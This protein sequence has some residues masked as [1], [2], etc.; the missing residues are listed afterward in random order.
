MKD[1]IQIN[2]VWYVRE[3]ETELTDNINVT[4]V[5]Q[6]TYETDEYA[7]EASRIYKDDLET[8]YSGVDVKFTDKKK[9]Y[10]DYWDNN[11]YLLGVLNNDNYFINLARENMNV[12]GIKDFKNFIYYLKEKG[13]FNK[14]NK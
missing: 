9:N 14:E 10:D 4:H 7:W 11:D 1:R 5:Q 12:E 2:G 13:W 3:D 8:F 6:C